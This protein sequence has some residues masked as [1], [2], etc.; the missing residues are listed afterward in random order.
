MHS[1]H[2]LL[3]LPPASR[4]EGEKHL[5][6]QLT[7]LSPAETTHVKQDG[8]QTSDLEA[9]DHAKRRMTLL[10]HVSAASWNAVDAATSVVGVPGATTEST[11]PSSTSQQHSEAHN[12]SAEDPLQAAFDASMEEDLDA[13]LSTAARGESGQASLLEEVGG[14]AAQETK[15]LHDAQSHAMGRGSL[16]SNGGSLATDW[17]LAMSRGKVRPNAR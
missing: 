11:A 4:S 3:S 6:V 17:A 13:A 16:S 8:A 9:R 1:T 10:L 5:S 15:T 2:Y 14:A 7:T 12:Q